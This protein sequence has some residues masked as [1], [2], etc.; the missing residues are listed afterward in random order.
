MRV[1]VCK[2]CGHA[3]GEDDFSLMCCPVCDSFMELDRLQKKLE[4]DLVKIIRIDE[5]VRLKEKA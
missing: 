1:I 2:E 4:P 5:T 3:V